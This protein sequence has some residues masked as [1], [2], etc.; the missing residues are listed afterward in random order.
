[1]RTSPVDLKSKY[2]FSHNV[3]YGPEK[4]E[5]CTKL[6]VT[7][8]NIAGSSLGRTFIATLWVGAFFNVVQFYNTLFIVHLI[9]TWWQWN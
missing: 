4:L 7:L 3:S 2:L 1:M 8:V 5:Q 9:S 6:M